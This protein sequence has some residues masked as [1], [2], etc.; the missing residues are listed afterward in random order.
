[1][2]AQPEKFG[3]GGGRGD[4]FLGG[5]KSSWQ[6]KACPVGDTWGFSL[7]I[8][9]V[10]MFNSIT[11]QVHVCVTPPVCPPPPK[12]RQQIVKMSNYMYFDSRHVLIQ[13]NPSRHYLHCRAPGGGLV[14]CWNQSLSL[15]VILHKRGRRRI[16]RGS[17]HCSKFRCSDYVSSLMFIPQ[18]R[19]CLQLC[20]LSKI[21]CFLLCN[22]WHVGENI[23]A[24]SFQ[25]SYFLYLGFCSVV[26]GLGSLRLTGVAGLAR[27]D[28]SG[29]TEKNITALS[30]IMNFSLAYSDGGETGF[31][32]GLP[33][34]IPRL[35]TLPLFGHWNC[36]LPLTF[37]QNVS[38]YLQRWAIPL[39]IQP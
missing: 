20:W 8:I 36:L 10:W 18:Q 32:E 15:A 29:V 33:S 22:G 7:Y 37:Q 6:S 16:S 3:P 23:L 14:P 5:P 13:G 34:D 4:H 24:C 38:F 1:M 27:T 9:S 21:G 28:S 35:T 19:L 31:L 17:T 25:L 30:P 12:K 26:S 39:H 11:P 2:H